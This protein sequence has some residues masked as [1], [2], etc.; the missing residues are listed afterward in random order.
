MVSGFSICW[1]SVCNVSRTGSAAIL[2]DREVGARARELLGDA[3][4]LLARI[5]REKLLTLRGVYGFFPA[6]SVGDDIEV[7]TDQ[8]RKTVRVTLHTLRQQM[9]KP[10]TTLDKAYYA[11]ADF[12]APKESKLADYIGAFAVTSGHGMAEL[13]RRFEGENDVYNTIM[14]KALADRLA[15][16]FAEYLHKKAREAWGYG[17]AEK[18]SYVDLLREK[19]RGIRPAPGYPACPEHSEKRLLFDL[20]QA[21]KNAGMAL[22]EIFAMSPASSICGLY[23]AHPKAR[24]FAIGKLG[25]DQLADYA[26]RKGM[27]VDEV[28]RWVGA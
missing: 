4:K 10:E 9:E 15:E 5:E 3:R 1:R 28:K 24:Y 23:F 19:Y 13:T 22:T 8:T 18:L 2:E 7:Y 11:L 26:A 20:L 21:E 12:V 17:H 14:A 25:P 27:S 16:A 6:N